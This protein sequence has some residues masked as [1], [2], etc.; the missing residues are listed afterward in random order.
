MQFHE[1]PL[2][3]LFGYKT[4]VDVLTHKNMLLSPR[5]GD[6]KLDL[7]AECGQDPWL[8]HSCVLRIRCAS[9]HA[10]LPKDF[11][12]RR[13]KSRGEW[14][15]ASVNSMRGD[16]VCIEGGLRLALEFVYTARVDF[17]AKPPLTLVHGFALAERLSLGALADR[18]V[19]HVARAISVDTFFI[20]M[21]RAD[22]LQLAR[23]RAVA[24]DFATRN[25]KQV[26]RRKQQAKNM[27]LDLYQEM[28]AIAMNR[29]LEG[30]DDDSGDSD[31]NDNDQKDGD[32]DDYVSLRDVAAAASSSK[33]AGKVVRIADDAT[34]SSSR[35]GAADDE[36]RRWENCKAQLVGDFRRLWDEL[37]RGDD[38]GDAVVQCNDGVEVRFHRAL[39]AGHSKPWSE[40]LSE[41]AA[42][43]SRLP[44]DLTPLLFA[45]RR[46]LAM[47]SSA[48]SAALRFVYYRDEHFSALDAC[49]VSPF[50]F[51]H[52]LLDMQARAERAMVENITADDVVNI[53]R[54][55]YRPENRTR[56]EMTTIARRCLDFL[57]TPEHLVNVDFDQ[58]RDNDEVDQMISVDVLRR[59][60]KDVLRRRNVTSTSADTATA[61]VPSSLLSSA[62]DDVSDYDASQV[63]DLDTHR[64]GDVD[65][66]FSSDGAAASS[67]STG[68]SSANKL[69]AP[70][71]LS[72]AMSSAASATEPSSASSSSSSSSSRKSKRASRTIGAASKTSKK[73][74]GKGKS[75]TKG[76]KIRDRRSARLK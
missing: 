71:M 37:V 22:E 75:K 49:S 57:A 36:C 6:V 48:F 10:Q 4:D 42:S 41:S 50:A 13:R 32:D 35:G 28:A 25:I 67:S 46:S 60:Q 1:Q 68:D 43:S 52:G 27:G 23:L 8:V 34:A 26:L 11:L 53:L 29:A 3:W 39:L 72:S 51:A 70:P 64:D 40:Q 56:H 44:V 5:L 9:L 54:V 73:S 19:D 15:V 74:K 55:T 12:K 18:I 76:S 59:L 16:R 2:R 62:T 7:G 65:E 20:Y 38:P 45:E 61:I 69:V 30:V 47:P 58:L 17:D 24:T 14:T 21:K 31:D 66:H 63:G 33:N